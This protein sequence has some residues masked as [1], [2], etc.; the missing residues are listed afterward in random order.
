MAIFDLLIGLFN[1]DELFPHLIGQCS[2]TTFSL[3]SWDVTMRCILIHR[4]F[5]GSAHFRAAYYWRFCLFGV[6]DSN[7]STCILTHW[8]ELSNIVLEWVYLTN[9]LGVVLFAS[10]AWFHFNIKINIT[11]T[12]K[13]IKSSKAGLQGFINAF[14]LGYETSLFLKFLVW[15]IVISR[16]ALLNIDFGDN[17]SKFDSFLVVSQREWDGGYKAACTSINEWIGL[18]DKMS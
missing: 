9:D 10:F 16:K 18:V 2:F 5:I 7:S 8:Y 11:V 1:L 13:K 14:Y 15:H 17:L 3:F 12:L 4:S 6:R